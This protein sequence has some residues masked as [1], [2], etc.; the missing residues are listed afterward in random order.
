MITEILTDIVAV[1]GVAFSMYA[2]LQL[3][4]MLQAEL[5]YWSAKRAMRHFSTPAPPE[6]W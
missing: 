4:I 1:W 6:C 5:R 2:G 3:F